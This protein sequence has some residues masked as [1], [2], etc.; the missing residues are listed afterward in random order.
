MN[1]AI[2]IA[3]LTFAKISCNDN[4]TSTAT[5][6]ATGNSDSIGATGENPG[7]GKLDTGIE[8]GFHA[9]TVSHHTNKADTLAP[10]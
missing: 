3:L 10:Q 2:I 5:N 8:K 7:T 6:P 1:K 4:Q 9:D